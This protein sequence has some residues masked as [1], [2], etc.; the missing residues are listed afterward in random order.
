MNPAARRV[1]EVK[2]GHGTEVT[3]SVDAPNGV[4]SLLRVFRPAEVV[5]AEAF[6]TQDV[7]AIRFGASL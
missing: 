1:N 3:A 2:S 6:V 7:V 5:A 4:R